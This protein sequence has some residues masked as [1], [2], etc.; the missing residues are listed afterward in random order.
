MAKKVTTTAVKSSAPKITAGPA[1]SAAPASSPGPVITGSTPVRNSAI[2]KVA[3]TP[4]P[5]KREIT[6]DQVAR[7]AYEI[8]Q[9]GTGGTPDENWFRAERELRGL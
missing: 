1:R 8:S 7:R 2:P 3:A 9:S 4:A 6:P 5:A